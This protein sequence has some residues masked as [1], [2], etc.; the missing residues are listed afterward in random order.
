MIS[1]E[2]AQGEAGGV[3]SAHAVDAAAWGS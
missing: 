2:V 3:G 1:F